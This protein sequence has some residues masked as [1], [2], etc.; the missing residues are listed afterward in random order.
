MREL[1]NRGLVVLL[2]VLSGCVLLYNA[3][4]PVLAVTASFFLV[5]YVCYSLVV[6]DSLV[7]PQAFDLF[8]YIKETASVLTKLL[9]KSFLLASGHLQNFWKNVKSS[10][11]ERLV[12][13]MQRRKR[14]YQLS[15][16]TCI[17]SRDTSRMSLAGGLSPIPKVGYCRSLLNDSENGD[18]TC[19]QVGSYGKTTSTPL[20]PGKMGDTRNGDIQ[21]K[22]NSTVCR[23]KSS[24]QSLSHVLSRGD[25]VTYFTPNGSPWGQSISPQMRPKAAGVKTVQT[26][27]GPLLASTRYNI[28]SKVYTD[29][30]SPG[31]TTRLSKYATEANTKLTHQPQYGTGQFPKVNLNA[32]PIPVIN[33]KSIKLRAQNTIRVAP[34]EAIKYCPPEKQKILSS[35]C[36]NDYIS[37][38]P[39]AAVREISLKR[40][41]SKEDV[42]SEAVKK[43]RTDIIFSSDLTGIEEAKGKRGRDESRS[44]EEISPQ[45][46]SVRPAKRTKTPSCYDIINSLTSSIN[47]TSGLKRKAIDS[48]RSETPDSGKHFKSHD[49]VQNASSQSIL[50]LQKDKSVQ[51]EPSSSDKTP[52]VSSGIQKKSLSLEEPPLEDTY[53]LLK[54]S[55]IRSKKLISAAP[56]KTK[57]PND[58]V[59]KKSAELT[60][61]LFM[62]AEPRINDKLKT[63]VNEH[64]KIKPK[65]A[66]ENVEEIRKED[67]V[68]M[69][70]TS[71]RARL[72]SMFDA[73]SGKAPSKINPDIVI[74][75]EEIAASPAVSTP[76]TRVSLNSCTT[77]TTVNTSPIATSAI[78][79][80]ISPLNHNQSEKHVTFSLLPTETKSKIES[81]FP[82]P[83]LNT[84][85]K[86][87][88]CLPA[89]T[90]NI[91]SSTSSILSSPK[92]IEA[93]QFNFTALKS[94]A[95]STTM[96]TFS[97][98]TT[99][100]TTSSVSIPSSTAISNTTA[101]S[102]AP[103]TS[104]SMNFMTTA[105]ATNTRTTPGFTGF[106]TSAMQPQKSP[107]AVSFKGP[108]T[109]TTILSTP[110]TTSPQFSLPSMSN[111]VNATKITTTTSTPTSGSLFSSS[112]E[113]PKNSL[114][115]FGAKTTTN[116]PQTPKTESF[117]FTG[118]SNTPNTENSIIR[119]NT[120]NTS[121]APMTTANFP[122]ERK[123]S[124]ISATSAFGKT[125]TGTPAFA[126]T[127]SKFTFGANTTNTNAVTNKPMF[128]FGAT[129]KTEDGDKPKTTVAFGI[130]I[131]SATNPIPAFGTPSTSTTTQIS[132][133]DTSSTSNSQVSVFGTPSTSS[134]NLPSAF[135]T[136]SISSNIQGPTFG[137][138]A[139]TS[140]QF[141]STNTSIFGNTSNN[142]F[143][144][145]GNTFGTPKTTSITTTVPIFGGP[146]QGATTTA[147]MVFGTANQR[148][149]ITT[150]PVFAS[151][152]QGSTTSA[153]TIF[154]SAVSSA[155]PSTATVFGTTTTSS[156]P[157]LFTN[158]SSSTNANSTTS[159]T[160]MFS[161]S[162]SIFG[163]TK[164][165]TSFV[166]S[167]VT[168]GSGSSVFG[169]TA[170][171]AFGG[172]N[173]TITTTASSFNSISTTPA[174]GTSGQSAATSAVPAAFR[175]SAPASVSSPVSAFATNNTAT[176]VFGSTTS[177]SGFGGAAS[178][179]GSQNTNN[180]SFGKTTG[181]DTGSSPF[182]TQAATT[183]AF[184]SPAASTSGF[185]ANKTGTF[186]FG[187]NSST[188]AN[189]TFTFGGS[190]STT[191]NNNQNSGS[192]TALFQFGGNNSKPASAGFNFTSPTAAPI[193]SFGTPATP[194]FN[195]T[196]GMFSIGSGSTAPRSRTTRIKKTR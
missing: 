156:I 164:S 81:S 140:Q 178:S 152:S 180:I 63:L 186:S 23:R 119:T 141:G 77:T 173:T 86:K 95:I 106:N 188:Q 6:N 41:V 14:S 168:F 153:T 110:A 19:N 74:Q 60:D 132:A 88:D 76:V 89:S 58:P 189:A 123:T 109:S 137:I 134:S 135:T 174:F 108:T 116:N 21:S 163:Q 64:T 31:L 104:S 83:K 102:S 117:T 71:M 179:F 55:L 196:P 118:S 40:H 177:S 5:A 157:S 22:S 170:Q 101:S 139:T 94:D 144:S 34:P 103:S 129:S 39:S 148:A 54:E 24:L 72:Q 162:G 165:P 160:T 93:P 192:N 44:E 27:A 11:R 4:G 136:P 73:I 190:S 120:Q 36:H 1:M 37:V 48:S 115:T 175:P 138:P 51:S 100:N 130:G 20:M 65:F 167:P 96:N 151:T 68:N 69:R 191:T 30:M 49:A 193:A 3:W 122:S 75:A 70:K 17:N 169:Q 121:I 155:T 15:S 181:F 171:P 99:T 59:L 146:I 185:G 159:S 172:N 10:Y 26:V 33:T 176:P 84:T 128:T 25:N 161:Q 61:K 29:I 50:D 194:T 80:T 126:S 9:Q 124:P 16:D 7:S 12:D 183:S 46:K 97:F 114:F 42:M 166:S 8:N 62:R 113:T 127:S 195:A 52:E 57:E 35:V 125:I 85:V 112:T 28:D 82:V 131:T 107:P 142:L 147:S 92:S 79:P 91:T 43:Q 47:V 32:N 98:H 133:F 149:T 18:P 184:G 87:D 111:T 105:S 182:A 187:T 53:K 143:A 158:S 13:K 150:S 2:T 145:T 78:A 90:S 56:L 67:I 154:G 38:A 45:N 66:S